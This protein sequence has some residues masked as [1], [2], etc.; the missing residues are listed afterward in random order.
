MVFYYY[1]RDKTDKSKSTDENDKVEKLNIMDKPPTPI[2][3]SKDIHL[4]PTSSLT[5]NSSG[6]YFLECNKFFK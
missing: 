4:E 3:D 6:K 2:L 1:F 5:S